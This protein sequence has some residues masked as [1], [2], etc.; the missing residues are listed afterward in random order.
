MIERLKLP[1]GAPRAIV[2][3]VLIIAVGGSPAVGAAAGGPWSGQ[4]PSRPQVLIDPNAPEASQPATAP[5]PQ[6]PQMVAGGRKLYVDLCQRCHGLNMVS[7]G[8]GFFDLRGFPP[9]QK[10][11]FVD[12]VSNGKRAMP[13]W[14]GLLKPADID[15]LWAY[16]ATGGSK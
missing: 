1:A 8:A 16:V 14:G 6:D 13:A 3:A 5:L 11:R 9:D 15:L 7:S 4:A 2:A 10:Q 12:S